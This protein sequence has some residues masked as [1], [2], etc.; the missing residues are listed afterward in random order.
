MTQRLK[1]PSTRMSAERF[2]VLV[3]AVLGLGGAG[4]L[5]L[6]GALLRPMRSE[7]GVPTPVFTVIALPS[8]TPTRVPSTPTPVGLTPT[9]APTLPSGGGQGFAPGDL[10]EVGGTG[11]EGLR[12]RR[13]PNLN[14]EIVVLGLDSEVFRVIAGPTEADGYTWW[15]LV[16]P[17]D[18]SKQG[19]AVGLYLRKLGATP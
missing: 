19:W 4:C 17:Y 16:N 12:L 8:E 11:G 18:S 9:P 15:H 6:A 3:A 7:G 2:I 14:A 13:Q 10:V 5:V 1:P